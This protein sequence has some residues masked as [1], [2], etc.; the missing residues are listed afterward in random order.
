[1]SQSEAA[2]LPDPRTGQKAFLLVA[3]DML[4]AGRRSM[5]WDEFAKLAAVEPRALKTYRMPV[6]SNDYRSMPRLLVEK[7][8]GMVRAAND[9]KAPTPQ[10]PPLNDSDGRRLSTEVLKLLPAALAALVI[11][12]ARQVFAGGGAAMISGVDRLRTSG[13][14]LAPEDRRAMAL[15]SRALL[16]L[17]R[18]DIGAEIHQLLAHCTQVFSDWIPIDEILNSGLG[19]VRLI[20]PDDLVPTLEAEE[21]AAGFGGLTS[22]LEE[23]VFAAFKEALSKQ[24]QKMADTYYTMVRTFVVRNP[25]VA[26]RDM[27]QQMVDIEQPLPTQIF[28]C[29]ESFYEPLQ[30]S[31]GQG[32][33]VQLCQHCKNLMRLSAGGLRCTTKACAATHGSSADHPVSASELLRLNRALRKY[34]QEPG[35]DE[36]R[37]ADK[38]AA[39]G[40]T[41]RLYPHRDLVDIDLGEGFD[42]GIDLKA[43]SSPELL[44]ERLK[45]RPGGLSQYAKKLLV[46]PDWLARR[47]AGYIDRLISCLDGSSIRAM[48]LSDALKELG[49]A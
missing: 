30:G 25:V 15:V 26:R 14:G 38:L 18:P 33:M 5:T 11:R 10:D 39:A 24:P 40:H 1:M 41:V 49:H 35:I 34:W 6:D 8:E 45:R 27:I 4:S 37:L 28:A 17:G 23:Q 7:I 42:V 9:V 22:A 16:T 32:T 20:D 13:T 44:G 46:V 12:Q 36:M 2:G 19:R 21:L 29:L 48:T 43:Y 3:K 31:L 47:E